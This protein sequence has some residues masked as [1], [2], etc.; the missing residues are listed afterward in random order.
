ME[1]EI[2]LFGL[3]ISAWP[4]WLILLIGVIGVLV[5]FLVQGTSQET[6]YT[7]YPFRE[8]IFFTFIQFL[9]Y[10]ILSSPYIISLL[11]GKSTL[12]SSFKYYFFTSFCLCCSMGLSNLSVERLSYPT[13]VLFKSSKLIPVMIGGMIF[14]NKKYN[15][16]EILSI[17][18]IVSG[19]IG[20]SYSDKVSKNKF[21]LIGVFLSVI[22]LVFDAVASNLQEKALSEHGASQNELISMMYLIG[23]FIM[24][25][26]ALVSGQLFR[27][28]SLCMKYPPMIFYLASF[29]F[30]GSIG[31]QFVYL[32]MKAFGSL[33]TVMVTSTR[34]AATVCISFVLFPNKKFT[35]FHLGSILTIA[36]GL[37]LNYLGKSQA[38]RKNDVK[39]LPNHFNETTPF[40]PKRQDFRGDIDKSPS[41]LEGV[42]HTAVKSG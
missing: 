12:H 37:A 18:L 24:F 34:K 30:L 3:D 4:K 10:F 31:V 17:G 28:V 14:L 11:R 39:M 22:S 16:L 7:R 36:S 8:S 26:V 38:K 25:F 32:L 27:G 13:A 29:A 2:R 33:V 42:K 9:G 15:F 5:S 35:F 41:G 1:N 20:V 40:L 21:D 19:L 6:L 23:S